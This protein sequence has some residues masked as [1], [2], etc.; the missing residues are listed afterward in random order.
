MECL[1]TFTVN[2]SAQKT[3]TAPEAKFWGSAPQNYWVVETGFASTSLFNIE[4]FKNINIYKIKAVG[5]IGS[6]INS[7]SKVIVDNWSWWLKI[8]GRV[9][10]IGGIV[11]NTPNFFAMSIETVNPNFVLDKYNR[12]IE[13]EDPI[14]SSTFFEV[15]GLQA[16]GIGSQDLTSVNLE[17][18]FTFVVYYKFEGED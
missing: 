13:F 12:T 18:Q 15:L 14:T 5:N 11:R 6:Q 10:N 2:I 17:W 9:Q 4:G 1:K 3:I 7:T 8:G 16:S